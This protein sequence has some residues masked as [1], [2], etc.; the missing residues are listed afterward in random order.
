MV[1][2]VTSRGS[3][4]S[5]GSVPFTARTVQGWN[6]VRGYTA[7]LYN[8]AISEADQ[9]DEELRHAPKPDCHRPTDAWRLPV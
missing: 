4:A 6:F 2:G 5:P 1:P 7:E 8:R 9:L 3:V